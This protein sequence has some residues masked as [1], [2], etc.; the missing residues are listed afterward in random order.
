MMR[1]TGPSVLVKS[2]MLCP[3]C[4]A[5][6][7]GILRRPPLPLAAA[8]T[9]RRGALARARRAATPAAAAPGRATTVAPAI[10]PGG[11]VGG[12]EKGGA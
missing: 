12:R 3:A 10:A 4:W 7:P 11:R 2:G 5:C 9:L 6:C 1:N 8:A